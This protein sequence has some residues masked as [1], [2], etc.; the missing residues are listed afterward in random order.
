MTLGNLLSSLFSSRRD[1]GSGRGRN[2][3][4]ARPAIESLE[5][6]QLLSTT[7]PETSYSGPA[8]ITFQD[9]ITNTWAPYIA[10]EGRDSQYHLNIENL[11][12]G[13]KV[14]L[15]ETTIGSPALAVYQGR[16]FIAWTGTDPQHHLNVESS[17]DGLTF[18]YKTVLG[19]TSNPPEGPVLV[20]HD[21]ALVIGWAG[22]DLRLNYA[23]SFD[24][25]GRH[26]TPANT[27]PYHSF[28]RPALGTFNGDFAVSWTDLD[29]NR[30]RT[31]SITH[32]TFEPDPDVMNWGGPSEAVDDGFPPASY[33]GIARTD[34]STF[35]VYVF[36][37]EFGGGEIAV[38]RSLWAPSLAVDEIPDNNH[39]YVAWL[40]LDGHLYYDV[41]WGGGAP[42][43]GATSRDGPARATPDGQQNVAWAGTGH[44]LE[45]LDQVNGIR[46]SGGPINVTS[47][48]AP[49]L[50]ADRDLHF[51]WMDRNAQIQT[52]DMNE[53]A[54]RNTDES[55][56]DGPGRATDVAG[57]RR[58]AWTRAEDDFSLFGG[59][60][61]SETV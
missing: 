14:T 41:L 3:S 8:V 4:R 29:D 17:A 9:Q 45:V 37:L 50:A 15:P 46:P 57:T 60:L 40:G 55:N 13:A 1:R 27:L 24:T 39:F 31:W 44:Q 34:M 12:T 21:Q 51:A 59:D 19:Q 18:S 38:G 43:Q 11:Y 2:L 47:Q 61:G 5:D 23:Y 22:T 56:H 54:A 58:T 53:R 25:F 16:L 26:W 30:Y 42:Y 28:Y 6:R 48:N 36:S 32:Q 10:W 49:S 20:V 52:D 33:L 35:N 7:L